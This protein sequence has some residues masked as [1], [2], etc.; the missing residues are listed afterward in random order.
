MKDM[1][2]LIIVNNDVDTDPRVLNQ[3]EALKDHASIYFMA[4]S[5]KKIPCKGFFNFASLTRRYIFH[6]GYPFLIRKFLTLFILLYKAILR[7]IVR[8]KYK[9]LYQRRYW[10]DIRVNELNKI[11]NQYTFD[12]IIA[13]DIDTL[14][15]AAFLKKQNTKLIF[16]AHEYF[17]E[18][19]EASAWIEKEYP[20]RKYLIDEYLKCIDVFMTVG[21][22]IAMRFEKELQLIQKPLVIFNAKPYFDS[23]PSPTNPD[24]IRMVHHGVAIPNRNL[25]S[26]IEVMR[27]LPSNYEIHFYL[28]V[29][30]D[31]YAAALYS[32]ARGVKN[33]F[34]H[35]PV[36]FSQ[37]IPTIAVYDIGLYLIEKNNYNNANCLP[38]KVFEFIQAKLALIMS[39]TYEVEKLLKKYQNGV[40]VDGDVKNIAHTIKNITVQEIEQYKKRSALAAK[41]LSAEAEWQKIRKIVGIK[42]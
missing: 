39:H 38:N 19:N 8:H 16:D 35:P 37:I 30:D 1:K 25:E 12:C 5:V 15:I 2:I 3:W 11:K 34:F 28:K 32:L 27:Y 23:P 42:Q 18:E 10:Q 24:I 29:I 20:F 22:N 14:P 33:V 4:N 6:Y 21:E 9:N 40:I 17:L 7:L 41:E 13:N 31:N 26:L 36:P